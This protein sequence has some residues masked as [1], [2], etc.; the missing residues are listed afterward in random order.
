MFD[1]ALFNS[2]TRL[3]DFQA[4]VW[5]V[6]ESQE[7]IATLSLV[8]NMH[9]Q[10]ILETLLDDIKPAYR[11][12]TD[13]MHYLI[14]TAFRYP[15]LKHG[16]RFGK[17]TQASYFYASLN[18]ETA[19]IETAY[20]RFL[21]LLDMQNE[22]TKPLDSEHT[23]FSVSVKSE[24]CLNLRAKRYKKIRQ[25]LIHPC[26]YAMTQAI[27]EW[28]VNQKQVEVIEFES[29]RRLETSNVAISEPRCIRSRKP[30]DYQKWLCRSSLSQVSFN[31]RERQTP[32]V[33]ARKSFLDKQGKFQ[34]IN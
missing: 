27:G 23:V 7:T 18:V 22:Y 8:D 12:G 14:K 31:S 11:Q 16:S 33:I 17:R 13:N 2:R 28:A 19:L 10:G 20:Y 15:P 26:D 30:L 29:A 6:V 3:Q 9:E 21:F 24:R 34:S 5:R 25:E 1:Q 4:K 32:L